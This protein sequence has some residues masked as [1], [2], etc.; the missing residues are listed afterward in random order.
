MQSGII[1]NEI[2]GPKGTAT[3]C[4]V[5][6]QVAESDAFRVAAVETLRL[7]PD[8]AQFGQD[9][10]RSSEWPGVSGPGTTLILRDLVSAGKPSVM[11]KLVSMKPLQ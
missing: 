8:H 1:L 3:S 6:A 10:A 4:A 7:S 9:G 5:A 2:S 11:L